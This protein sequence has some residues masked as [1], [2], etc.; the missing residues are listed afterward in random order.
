MKKTFKRIVSTA[1]ATTMLMSTVMVSVSAAETEKPQQKYSAFK[2]SYINED[3]EIVSNVSYSSLP[4]FR[5]SRA[6]LPAS[7][8]SADY[9]YVTSVKNQ[10]N[11]GTCWAFAT[12]AACE[13]SMIKNNGYDNNL[14]LAELLLCYAA[15]VKQSD[16]MGFFDNYIN[17]YTQL[18]IGEYLNYGGTTGDALITLANQQGVAKESANHGQFSTEKMLLEDGSN[19]LVYNPEALYAY[20]EAYVSNGYKIPTSNQDLVKEHIIKY[21]AGVMNINSHYRNDDETA[22][23]TYESEY[24]NHAV[25]VVGWDDNY[26][27]ENC[28]VN[29]HTP[30]NDGAWLIKNSWGEEVGNEGYMW[31]S[32]EDAVLASDSNIV[33]FFELSPDG[34]YTNCYQYDNGAEEMFLYNGDYESEDIELFV[35]G[36]Y[37]SNVFTAQKDNETLEAVSFYTSNDKLDYTVDIYTDVKGVDDPTNGTLKATFSG[38]D[39]LMGYHT[40]ELPEA[41][42]LNKGEKFSVV[43]NIKDNQDSSRGV[44]VNVGDCYNNT[45][46]EGNS[47]FSVN[48]ESWDDL[49]DCD[50]SYNS[51]NVRVKA[52]TNSDET[53]FDVVDYYDS[54]NGKTR[55]EL[56]T[57]FKNTLDKCKQVIY[58]YHE[59]STT[60]V[61]GVE[62]MYDYCMEAYKNSDLFLAIEISELNKF[63]NDLYNDLKPYDV[64]SIIADLNCEKLITAN[65]G[66][67]FKIKHWIEYKKICNSLI[68]ET[69]DVK[70]TE[71]QIQE[72]TEII[73]QAFMDCIYGMVYDG[74]FESGL[75]KYGDVDNSGDINIKDVT[76]IQQLI[77][78]NTKIAYTG[79]SKYDVNGDRE[80]NIKDVTDIQMYIAKLSKCLPI[81]LKQFGD[82]VVDENIDLDTAVSNLEEAVKNFEN[83]G[84]YIYVEA[85]PLRNIYCVI[86]KCYYEDAKKV[87]ENPEDYPPS[88]IDFKARKMNFELPY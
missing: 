51:Y 46:T 4:T 75:Q 85:D 80:I 33:A 67:F 41:V 47:F 66:G 53:P 23:Y 54:Y 14:D 81:Y 79:D 8:N 58:S 86:F 40:L 7:Y 32:Y 77:A 30:E 38:E 64:R 18:G 24:S 9:G 22:F 48:G 36:A 21:G 28:T 59:Y 27:K 37:M 84:L 29:G 20:N 55:E 10:G 78:N 73:R 31:V 44:Y 83:S 45:T 69:K 62:Y 88:V 42:S 87:L 11:T 70:L 3:G 52:F 34:K 71:E 2:A 1:L 5:R 13:S 25:A 57:E 61:E 72:Y 60:T 15:N 65:I 12:M 76:H 74:F 19:F 6:M 39:L 56:L 49:E 35:G 68:E 17:N 63:L 82:E 16:K 50:N 26:P 43:V